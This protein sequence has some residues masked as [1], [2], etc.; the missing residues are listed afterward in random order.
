M[1]YYLFNE[2]QHV[3]DNVIHKIRIY[4]SD[5]FAPM[6]KILTYQSEKRKPIRQN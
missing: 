4:L 1:L 6:H 2:F 3:N 5:E